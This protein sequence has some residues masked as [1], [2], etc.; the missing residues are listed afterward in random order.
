MTPAFTHAVVLDFEATC[1]DRGPPRPQ[2]VIEFP[3]LL[4]SLATLEVVDSFEAFVRPHHRP[5]LTD[6]CRRFTSIAQ[7]DVDGA[8][9][10]TAVL[11]RHRDWLG[12]HGLS[13]DDEAV[14][15]F[16]SG[17]EGAPKGVAL[18]HRNIQANRF[19]ISS[20]IDFTNDD[21]VLNALPI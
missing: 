6:F 4:L 10:F 2:E 9:G 1:D 16:T 20:V 14:V 18:S 7:S 3:S 8:D 5:R 12:G 15:L 17:S 13:A 11:G 21:V 19:Q